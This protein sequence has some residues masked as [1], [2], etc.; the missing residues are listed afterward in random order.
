[1]PLS[2][3]VTY[4]LKKQ[5]RAGLPEDFHAESDD[6]NTVDA[7]VDALKKR[8]CKVTGIE[9]DDSAYSKLKR[10]KRSQG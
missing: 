5:P 1:M 8:G 3:G 6:K 10:L 4:N 2:V 7:I 9:A